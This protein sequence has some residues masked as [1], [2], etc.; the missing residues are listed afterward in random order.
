MA[1]SAIVRLLLSFVCL[2]ALP[3]PGAAARQFEIHRATS[4]VQ[5]DG[6]LDEAAWR[7]ALTIDLPYEWSPDD[8]VPPPVKTDFLVTYDDKYL[9]AGFKFADPHPEMAAYL[10]KPS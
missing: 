9:Y 5:V 8:N 3:R 4:A 10:R 2:L 7:D 6:V 1:R